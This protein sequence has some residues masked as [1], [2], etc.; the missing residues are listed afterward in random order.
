MFELVDAVDVCLDRSGHDVGVGTEAVIDVIVMLN[1]NV[2]LAEVV[3]TLRNGLDGHFL[4]G[5]LASDD[6]LEGL[7]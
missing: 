7:D 5:H 3:R 2:H 6:L 1:L 4:E